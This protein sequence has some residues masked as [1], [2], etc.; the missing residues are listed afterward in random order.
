M[1]QRGVPHVS[2]RGRGDLY[3][4]LMVATP[5]ELD[6]EQESLLRQLAELRGE[7][8]AEPR[9]GIMGRVR[10]AFRS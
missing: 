9:S 10:S 6:D 3:I 7:D 1:R 5:T 2:G 8:V 4:H